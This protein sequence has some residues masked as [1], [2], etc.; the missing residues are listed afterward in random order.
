MIISETDDSD[1]WDHLIDKVSTKPEH[2]SKLLNLAG[3]S[4]DPLK[5]IEKVTF[6]KIC[7]LF[8]SIFAILILNISRKWFFLTSKITEADFHVF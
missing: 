6:L 3:S 1:L 8:P 5:V 7:I 2:I 4:V